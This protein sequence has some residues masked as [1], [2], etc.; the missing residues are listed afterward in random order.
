ME[1]LAGVE[2][3]GRVFVYSVAGTEYVVVGFPARKH[4]VK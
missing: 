2:E 1:C 4:T 3:A